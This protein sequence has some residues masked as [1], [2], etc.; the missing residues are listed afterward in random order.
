MGVVLWAGAAW[1]APARAAE[2]PAASAPWLADRG[3]G[4]WTSIFGTYVRSREL[5]V[6]PFAEGYIDDDFEY[7]PEELGFGLDQD[8]RGKFRAAEG[9]IFMAYGLSDRLAVELEASVI[10]ARLDKAPDDPSSMPA[11]L[12]QSGQ[13]DWQLELDWTVAKETASR[14]EVFAMLEADPP[15]NRHKVLIGTPDWEYKFGVGAIRGLSWGTIAGRLSGIYSAEDGAVDT[16][17]YAIEY[18]KRVS[19]HWKVYGGIEGEQDEVELIGET[20]WHFSPNAY[21]RLN[22]ARGLSSKAVDWGPDVGVV[23]RFPRH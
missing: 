3:A 22:L 12:K 18:L 5:L 21:L 23:F 9:L 15:S 16:G 4:T 11:Q 14:P 13:G 2:P 8:F 6:M 17:E 20:Q 1:T 19:P 10:T 7:K